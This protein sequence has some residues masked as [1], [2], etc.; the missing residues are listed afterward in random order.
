MYLCS[1]VWFIMR[2]FF[3]LGEGCLAPQGCNPSISVFDWYICFLRRG[4]AV[5]K[6]LRQH[7]KKGIRQI[8]YRTSKRF[9]DLTL[10][11]IHCLI[12]S[13]VPFL[14]I[15]SLLSRVQLVYCSVTN[16]IFCWL[17]MPNLAYHLCIPFYK[18]ALLEW[19]MCGTWMSLSQIAFTQDLNAS[20]QNTQLCSNELAWNDKKKSV[21]FRTC[22]S[23][24]P[25]SKISVLKRM[26]VAIAICVRLLKEPV[27]LPFC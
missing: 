4:L 9:S 23:R 17:D 6:Q 27:L 3:I 24:G 12:H 13:A 7:L 5:F 1:P 8:I 19:S 2:Y 11:L 14:A 25:I 18:Y 10:F 22:I 20:N 26:L 15:K 21:H 16:Q